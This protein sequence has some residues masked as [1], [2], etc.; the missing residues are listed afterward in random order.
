MT[1]K[2]LIN[3]FHVDSIAVLLKHQ[4]MHNL[5]SRGEIR[6]LYSMTFQRA[7]REEGPLGKHLRSLML[8]IF[9]KNCG[10]DL[11][12][13]SL[14]RSFIWAVSTGDENLMYQI[15]AFRKDVLDPDTLEKAYNLA[16]TKSHFMT[17][18]F[19]SKIYRT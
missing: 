5:F 17:A 2:R 18:H 8:Q 15:E 6:G 9:I 4:K 11:T 19:L 7:I 10:D 1:M 13:A 12:A 3:K 16:S 14:K